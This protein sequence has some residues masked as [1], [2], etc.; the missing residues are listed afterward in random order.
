MISNGNNNKK[1]RVLLIDDSPLAL[2]VMKRIISSSPDIDVASEFRSAKEALEK[3]ASIDPDVICT[4]LHMPEM[5]GLEFTRQVM[6]KF[7]K[8][9]LV[10]S[11]SVERSSEN[12]FKLI[13][14]GAVDLFS[15][16]RGEME[17]GFKAHAD[18]FLSRIRVLS[19][20]H[21][22]RRFARRPGPGKMPHLASRPGSR[23]PEIVAI[24]ASTGGPQALSLILSGL[25]RDFP[26]PVVCVQHISDGFLAGLMEWLKGSS[27]LEVR[28]AVEGERPVPGRVY[29][30]EEGYHLIVGKD[31][32][33][34]YSREPFNPHRPSITVTFN[35]LAEYYGG[36]VLGVLL[37]GMGSDGA[38]GM[39]SIAS[40]GGGTIAQDEATSVI[41]SMPRRAIELG[42]ASEVLPLYEI[43]HS[44]LSRVS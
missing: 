38:E 37:T 43:S 28:K 17:A 2:A 33:F 29:F 8:P 21:V 40:A 1:I 5:D 41:F 10:V 32:R 34:A 18:E 35:S 31:G 30:P 24:G 23:R 14:A 6:E 26:V 20:V 39:R 11:V 22:F 3:L 13:E 19:G 42:G 36:G 15:K 27:A 4:D 25:P 16:P 9:I 44:I 12:A 7:P